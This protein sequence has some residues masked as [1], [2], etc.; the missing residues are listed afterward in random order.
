MT[1]LREVLARWALVHERLRHLFLGQDR[2]KEEILTCLLAGGHVLLEGVPGTRKTL[3]PPS[4]WP[5][6]LWVPLPARAAHARPDPRRPPRGQS[7][8]AGACRPSSSGPA[9]SSRTSSSPTSS[10]AP[11]ADAGRAARGHAGSGGATIDGS[12]TPICPSLPCSRPRPGESEGTY[13]LPEAPARPVP[14]AR[15]RRHPTAADETRM[16][17]TYASGRASTPTRWPPSSR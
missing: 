1:P 5:S 3:A 9:P 16:L 2:V 14:H 17:T 6:L 13:P 10:P 15:G 12:A 11:A 4:P 7:V 8:T